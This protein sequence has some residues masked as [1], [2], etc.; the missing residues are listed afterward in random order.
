MRI[1]LGSKVGAR[2]RVVAAAT[3]GL[4]LGAVAVTVPAWVLGTP[5]YSRAELNSAVETERENVLAEAEHTALTAA[6][7]A[8]ADLR[9]AKDQV[10]KLRQNTTQLQSKVDRHL[11]TIGRLQAR[12]RALAKDVA[13]AQPVPAQPVVPDTSSVPQP[14]EKAEPLTVKGTLKST[15][16]LGEHLQPWPSD[17]TGARQSYQVRVNNGADE[18]ITIAD[19]VSAG[20]SS[21]SEKH[22]ILSLG[23][24]MTYSAE[25]PAAEQAVY[26]FVAV[27]AAEPD[28]NLKAALVSPAELRDGTGPELYVSFCPEC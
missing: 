1:R 7:E 6:A 16:V 21:R 12:N 5:A 11:R 26:E 3:A 19:I 20:V 4:V 22:G 23:C 27:D 10:R 18:T 28:V 14:A 8:D 15:W 2:G 24:T 17:C 13:A 25:L 9:A